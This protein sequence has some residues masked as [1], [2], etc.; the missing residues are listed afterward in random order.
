MLTA[1]EVHQILRDTT[2]GIRSMRRI[3]QIG[4]DEI[5]CGLMTVDVDG[6]LITFF[7]DCGDLDYCDNCLAHDGRKYEFSSKDA[8]DPVGL[9]T[10]GEHR[11]LEELLRQI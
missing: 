1:Q 10:P 3:T 5:Y 8:F 11:L 4:W 6:W 9:L 2:M 7:I